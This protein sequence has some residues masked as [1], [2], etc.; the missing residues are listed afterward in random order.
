METRKLLN[1]IL[2]VLVIILCY[3]L[4]M[5]VFVGQKIH[6]LEEKIDSFPNILPDSLY[7]DTIPLFNAPY[8][9]DFIA[10]KELIEAIIQVESNGNPKAYNKSSGAT[11]CMQIM[12]VMVNEVNRINSLTKNGKYFYPKDRWDCEKSKEMFIIWKQ[13]HH[14]DST[15]EKI[16]RHWWG[17][18]RYGNSDMSLF[19][20]ERVKKNLEV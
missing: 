5:H 15:P 6:Q 1:T 7:V 3:I 10:D 11:G 9:D 8:D 4:C 12:P 13:F 20:W 18:P 17:G 19:Y 14:K 2:G 16:A